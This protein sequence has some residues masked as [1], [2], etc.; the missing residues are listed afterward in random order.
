VL[1]I[2]LPVFDLAMSFGKV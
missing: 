2:I 1:T